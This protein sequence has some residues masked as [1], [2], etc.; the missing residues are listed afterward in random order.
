MHLR[1]IAVVVVAL[2]AAVII[3]VIAG[4]AFM[5]LFGRDDPT[6]DDPAAYTKAFVQ[7]AIERYKRD[8]RQATAVASSHLRAPAAPTVTVA[9]TVHDGSAVRV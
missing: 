2:V 6:K 7:E 3:V 1:R 4:V 8:G 5:G 9:T